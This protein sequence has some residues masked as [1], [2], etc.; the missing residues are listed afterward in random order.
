[1]YSVNSTGDILSHP[2]QQRIPTP[3]QLCFPTLCFHLQLS[4]SQKLK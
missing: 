4:V 1:M 2:A 3:F